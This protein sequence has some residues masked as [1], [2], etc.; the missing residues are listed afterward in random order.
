MLTSTVA[1]AHAFVKSEPSRDWPDL[2][3]LFAPVPFLDY[4]GTEPPGHGYTIARSCFSLPV[5][6]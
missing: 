2:E 4:G 5:R 3:I 1:E 6:A